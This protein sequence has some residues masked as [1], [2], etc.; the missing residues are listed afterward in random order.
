MLR[1][2]QPE[3]DYEKA[4]FVIKNMSNFNGFKVSLESYP[5][6]YVLPTPQYDCTRPL[7]EEVHMKKK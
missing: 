5:K 2:A 4:R 7:C 3:S 1:R 6:M